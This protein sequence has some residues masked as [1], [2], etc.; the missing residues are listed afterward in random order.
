MASVFKQIAAST[1]DSEVVPAIAGQKV[2]VLA[3]SVVTGD[4]P[5]T[6]LFESGTS[7]AITGTYDWGNN[8]GIVLPYN[9]EG[10]FE[11]AKGQALT[12]TTGGGSNTQ[13]LVSYKYLP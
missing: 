4:T 13:L 12:A 3:L 5:S 1:G 10:W 11:T 8:G 9:P 6:I 2:R 7:T